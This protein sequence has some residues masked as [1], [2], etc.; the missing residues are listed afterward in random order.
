[1]SE[2]CHRAGSER[3]PLAELLQRNKEIA[4]Q[5]SADK[6][7]RLTDPAGYLGLAGVMVDRVLAG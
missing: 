6:I 4:G 1:M 2:L 5:L 7:R 3:T